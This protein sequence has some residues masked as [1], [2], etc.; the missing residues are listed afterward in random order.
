MDVGD[1]IA[2]PKLHAHHR[3]DGGS[4]CRLDS[5][6]AWL[7][8]GRIGCLAL[9]VA[10][11]KGEEGMQALPKKVLSL[12]LFGIAVTSLFCVQP[13]QAY[14]VTLQQVGSDVVA[15]GSGAI[16]L[17]GLTFLSVA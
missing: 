17:T 11:A 3:R 15:S 9:Q 6:S 16:N 14:S 13:A 12:I 2:E 4:R 1:W 7:R 8:F 10:V 5:F